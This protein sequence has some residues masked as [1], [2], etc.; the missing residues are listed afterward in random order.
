MK[1]S[2]LITIAV[3]ASMA[4]AFNAS[5]ENHGSTYSGSSYSSS[6]T[7]P[8]APRPFKVRNTDGTYTTVGAPTPSEGR[9]RVQQSD[10]PSNNEPKQKVTFLTNSAPRGTKTGYYAAAMLGFNID[11]FQGADITNFFG[12]GNSPFEGTPNIFNGAN[13]NQSLGPF[14]SVKFGY[15]WPF[16]ETIDQ[17]ERET[18]GLRLAGALEAEFIYLHGFHEFAGPGGNLSNDV[19]QITFAPMV[20][21]LLK[22]QWGRSE[23]YLGPGIGVALTIFDGDGGSAPD[24]E[25][26]GDLA[27]Q[28]ILGYEFH[29]NEEWSIFAESKYFNIQDVQYLNEGDIAN[30]LLGIGIKKQ[31]F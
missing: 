13:S 20:N 27:Y 15:V 4:T 24:E 21:F 10:L 2:L 12:L 31:L 28:F 22:A 18:G 26:L 25:S 5:A 3:S 29:M 16:G 14:A 11:S 19:Q 23:L 17:F 1:Q 9:L 6:A 8:P 30:V 7:A